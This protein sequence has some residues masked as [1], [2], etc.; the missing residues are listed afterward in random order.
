MKSGFGANLRPGRR[1]AAI[2]TVVFL[3]AVLASGCLYRGEGKE[4]SETAAIRSLAAVEQAVLAYRTTHGKFP[5][6]DGD[7]DALPHERNRIDFR[8]LRDQGFMQQIPSSAFE[9]GGYYYYVIADAEGSPS[10]KLLDVRV[11][12][13]TA[14]LQ[15]EVDGY[16]A[17]TGEWPFGEPAAP[18]FYAVDFDRLGIR[19]RQ[20]KSVFF[21]HYLPYVLHESGRVAIHY[22]LD[23]MLFVQQNGL[24]PEE[25]SDLWPLLVEK[26][27]FVPPAAFPYEWRGGEPVPVGPANGG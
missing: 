24:S 4:Q 16:H 3:T 12:Q 2:V 18:G 17:R 11:T 19:A 23:L 10:V 9:S 25:G 26:S 14:D 27:P 20:A 22:A 21:A 5:L 1:L 15:R 13:A 6:L 8:S 7:P